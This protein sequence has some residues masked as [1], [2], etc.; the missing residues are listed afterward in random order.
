MCICKGPRKILRGSLNPGEA[1]RDVLPLGI[2]CRQVSD[3][4]R[5]FRTIGAIPEGVFCWAGGRYLMTLEYI[6]Y[7]LFPAHR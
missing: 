3:Y 1:D 4:N 5:E 7:L 6:L 2:L